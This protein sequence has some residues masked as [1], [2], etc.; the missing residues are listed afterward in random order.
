[1]T[2]RIG[3]GKGGNYVSNS[4]RGKRA[5]E[6]RAANTRAEVEYMAKVYFEFLQF[7]KSTGINNMKLANKQFDNM[8]R[9][10]IELG[11]IKQESYNKFKSYISN[12][13][14]NPISMSKE[15]FIQAASDGFSSNITNCS[16]DTMK[17]MEKD[18]Y[19]LLTKYN[20]TMP[21][22]LFNALFISFGMNITNIY[23]DRSLKEYFEQLAGSY[24]F[25][26]VD[27]RGPEVIVDEGDGCSGSRVIRGQLWDNLDKR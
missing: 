10:Y 17:N 19:S 3:T 8:I 12:S 15:A 22:L 2:I 13:G 6:T 4:D 11:K 18:F 26:R 16:N 14:I 1:M 27:W 20:V 5:A 21:T 24:G 7:C 23:K 25:E 9:P